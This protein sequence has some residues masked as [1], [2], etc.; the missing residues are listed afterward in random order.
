MSKLSIAVVT[1]I[2]EHSML[3]ESLIGLKETYSICVFTTMKKE[4]AG[5][6]P[7]PTIRLKTVSENNTFMSD[8]EKHLEGFDIIICD[9]PNN[10]YSYQSLKAKKALKSRLLIYTNMTLANCPLHTANERAVM[11][12]VMDH[13]DHYLTHSK[14][15]ESCLHSIQVKASKITLL[16]P[17][18]QMTQFKPAASTQEKS[19]LR[20]RLCIADGDIIAL[21]TTP[22]E[23]QYGTFTLINAIKTLVTDKAPMRGFKLR[24]YSAGNLGTKLKQYVTEL[25]LEKY[26]Q[27]FSKDSLSYAEA[28]Q[29][30]DIYIDPNPGISEDSDDTSL[31]L[32]MLTKAMASGLAP[33]VVGNHFNHMLVS[34]RGYLVHQGDHIKLA[35][36]LGKLIRQTAIRKNMKAKVLNF[37][38]ENFS[39]PLLA[40]K[41]EKIIQNLKVKLV[42]NDK[43]QFD[44]IMRDIEQ[45]IQEKNFINA[46][47]LIEVCQQLDNLNIHQQALLYRYIGDCFTKLG[48]YQNGEESYHK[49][50]SNYPTNA[51]ALIGL[52]T[53]KLQQKEADKAIIYFQKAIEH[54]PNDGMAM[55]GLGLSF[56]QI[57]ELEEALKWCGRA[58]DREPLNGPAIFTLTQISYDLASFLPAEKYLTAYIN[59][60]PQDQNM[61]FALAGIKY[62][63]GKN[64]QAKMFLEEI[65]ALNP[66]DERALS[67]LDKIQARSIFG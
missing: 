9:E 35:K 60:K 42:I 25:D 66:N 39:A 22:L 8:L 21:C 63:L 24:F 34:D 1:N 56:Q 7:L 10:T 53:I 44:L 14:V 16:P 41:L 46:I 5:D 28:L 65:I 48:D 32:S 3:L 57:G 4:P 47:D 50:L 58:L 19:D 45:N 64:D 23:M 2:L 54:A 31:A 29:I 27:F 38:L 51:K 11:S 52:G 61:I 33:I 62:K 13:T 55:L 37:A 18:C 67:L 15:T 36:Y 26:V 59:L 12:E 40:K 6:Y 43:S 30:A 17:I 20:D 49:S